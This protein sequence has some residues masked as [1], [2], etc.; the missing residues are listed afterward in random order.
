MSI[1]Y[2]LTFPNGKIYIG[3]AATDDIMYFGS[4]DPKFIEKDFTRKQKRDFTIRR[5]TLWESRTATQADVNRKEREKILEYKANNPTIG[6]N[7]RPKYNLLEWEVGEKDKNQTLREKR[8]GGKFQMW[9][10][11]RGRW[12][13]VEIVNNQYKVHLRCTHSE[14][15]AR[16]VLEKLAPIS[17]ESTPNKRREEKMIITSNKSKSLI[18]TE[19]MKEALK[20]WKFLLFIRACIQQNLI[21]FCNLPQKCTIKTKTGKF[22][23]DLTSLTRN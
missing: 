9:E 20:I 16:E 17:K 21:D 13:V 15:E 1:V 23:L 10:S 14:D 7:Q 11:D 8:A 4:P 2:K 22:D 19:Q 12:G 18:P 3:Q 5:E 6:Y